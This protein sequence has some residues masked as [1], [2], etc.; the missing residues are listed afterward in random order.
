MGKTGVL[1]KIHS[2]LIPTIPSDA[3]W[4]YPESPTVKAFH[5]PAPEVGT[6]T[7]EKDGRT[8]RT[9]SVAL[10]NTEESRLIGVEKMQFNELS[11]EARTSTQKSDRN[12][13]PTLTFIALILLLAEWAL[14]QRRPGGWVVRSGANT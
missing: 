12:L 13:W 11:V 4:Q 9:L 2:K 1:P 8:E 5:I 6:Y 14:F 10:L 3:G 7:V